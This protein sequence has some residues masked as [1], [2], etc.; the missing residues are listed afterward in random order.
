[1][2]LES[3]TWIDAPPERVWARVADLAASPGIVP[4]LER[5]EPQADG[6]VAVGARSR[7]TFA[8][9]G[10]TVEA[11]AVVT[12]LDPP[13]RLAVRAEVAGLPVHVDVAWALASERGGTRVVQ[14]VDV[15]ARSFLARLAAGSLLGS[16]RGQHDLE[17]GL[18]RLK[19]AVEAA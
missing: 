10:Q 2:H 18:G 16:G 19:R 9:G 15:E 12:E 8:R 7:L 13:R 3:E 17:A 6:P 11:D 14:T 4:F 1:M 5:A